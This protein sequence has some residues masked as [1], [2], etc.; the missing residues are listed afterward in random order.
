MVL[1][2]SMMC[3][4]CNVEF[5]LPFGRVLSP[6]ESFLHDLNEKVAAIYYS[7]DLHAFCSFLW[8]FGPNFES[9]SS[10][11]SVLLHI[12]LMFIYHIAAFTCHRFV[13]F[14][15][16]FRWDQLGSWEGHLRIVCFDACFV[17]FLPLLS[18]KF[19]QSNFKI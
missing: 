3:R 12:L 18:F 13:N 16:S 4:W 6:E 9:L 1:I 10:D 17:F 5:P 11:Y 14:S 7:N 19:D 15:S 2:F 8:G